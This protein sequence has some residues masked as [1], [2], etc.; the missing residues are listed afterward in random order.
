[1]TAEDERPQKPPVMVMAALN[2]ARLTKHDHHALPVTPD[3]IAAEAALCSAAGAAAVHFHVRDR[4]GRHVLDA[5]LYRAATSAIRRAAGPELV[6]QVTTEAVARYGPEAQMALVRDLRPEAVSIALNEMLPADAD[7]RAFAAFLTW[8]H[9]EAIWPQFVLYDAGELE[10]FQA[11]KARSLIP[12]PRPSVLFVLG[13]YAHDGEADPA[14]LDRFLASLSD[15]DLDWAFCAF[16]GRVFEC[17]GRVVT[18]GGHVRIGFENN[19]RRA[20]GH[21]ARSNAE[22]VRDAVAV[23]AAAGRPPMTAAD[24]R[25]RLSFA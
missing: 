4:A 23:A 11:L 3:E 12:F 22:L 17:A 18:L 6:A 15:A 14:E 8:M 21:L 9:R 20:D 5:D 24:L 2:G 19:L 13:R 10:C 1:M 25:R 7:E 16:G